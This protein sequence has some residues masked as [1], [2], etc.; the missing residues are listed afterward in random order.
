ML[1]IRHARHGDY[2]RVL[3]GRGSG[4][5]LSDEGVGEAK[6]MAVRLRGQDIDAVHVSP[7]ARAVQ[8][9]AIVA[10]VLGLGVEEVSALDE[11]DF[12]GWTGR[13]FDAL[14]PDPAWQAWNAARGA[15]CPPGGET[16]GA[17]TARAVAHVEGIAARG[18]T[19]ACVSH[20][21]IIRGVV[22]HYLGLGF[23]NL[24]RFDID[25]ASVSR[26]VVGARGARVTGLNDTG[27]YEVG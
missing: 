18:G 15:A 17:A 23:D 19:I 4:A 11:I 27:A 8:T 2:G 22:A 16:Q 10:A 25:A 3:S 13:S 24:L 14:G 21:D 1:L 20:C 9:G 26:L 12:G 7:Q 6:R 5:V